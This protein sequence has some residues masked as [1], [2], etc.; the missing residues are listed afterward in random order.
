MDLDMIDIDKCCFDTIYFK[1]NVIL[2][3]AGI[4]GSSDDGSVPL[5]QPPSS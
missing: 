2:E 1:G 3:L 4:E 5:V